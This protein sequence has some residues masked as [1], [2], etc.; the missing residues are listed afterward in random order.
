MTAPG[1]RFGLRPETPR[2]LSRP[3]AEMNLTPLIDVLLVLLVIFMAAICL[4]QKGL[5]VTVPREVAGHEAPPVS[6]IVVEVAWDGRLTVNHE[7]VLIWDLEYRLREIFHQRADKTLYIMGDGSRRY[8][9][10]V[11]I[12]DAAK[13]AGVDR[14]AIVTDAM[15]KQG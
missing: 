8:G 3:A 15:R 2:P 4:T 6:P 14:V 7:D 11:Q 9:E 5:D 10:I 13:G 1:S 12:V